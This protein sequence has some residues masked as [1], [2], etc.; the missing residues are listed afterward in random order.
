MNM[1]VM[2]ELLVLL[3]H[4]GVAAMICVEALWARQV[5]SRGM[6]LSSG[7]M[8]AIACLNDLR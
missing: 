5:C 2:L 8:M 1:S 3:A 6:I 4:G 7:A